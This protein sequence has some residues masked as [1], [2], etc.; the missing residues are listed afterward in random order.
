MT[1]AELFCAIFGKRVVLV[2]STSNASRLCKRRRGVLQR[3]LA[4]CERER[5][6][7]ARKFLGMTSEGPVKLWDVSVA[8]A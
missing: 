4:T 1:L 3:A 5:L 7:E 2:F 8:A 6:D